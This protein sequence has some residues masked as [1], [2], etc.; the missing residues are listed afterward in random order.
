MTWY[1]PPRFLGE[2]HR[3]R[4]SR[5]SIDLGAAHGVPGILGMLA[6]FVEADL[7]AARAYRL[8]E[9][10]VAWLLDTVPLDAPRFGTT[11]PP[12]DDNERKPLGWCHGDPGVAGALLHAGR[13][14]GSPRVEADAL[15]LLHRLP[16]PLSRRGVDDGGFCHGAAGIAH[17]YHVAFQRTGSALMR[18]HAE[19]WLTRMLRLRRSGIGTGPGTG[20]AGTASRRLANGIP[21]WEADPTL[22][23]GATGIA[24]VLL[25]ATEDRAPAWQHLFGL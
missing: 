15:E 23:S 7:E 10:A 2:P 6:R 24:L 17:I 13:A 18:Q 21:C 4:F 9:A 12:G 25:A 8:L 5:G 22:I 19:Y 20:I 11:W 3:A 16:G 1:T 14:L